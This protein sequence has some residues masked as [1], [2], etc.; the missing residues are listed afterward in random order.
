MHQQPGE[1]QP[2]S[3][4]PTPAPPTPAPPTPAPPTI[5]AEQAV[6]NALAGLA[7]LDLVPVCEHPAVYEAVHR[8]LQ[9]ALADL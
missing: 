2:A 5:A 3:P 7:E 9:D 8:G 1:G 6:T 4:A